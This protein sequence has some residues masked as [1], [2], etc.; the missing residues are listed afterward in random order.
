M[1]LAPYNYMV[2]PQLLGFLLI[3]FLLAGPL[4]SS[5]E[6]HSGFGIGGARPDNARGQGAAQS[7]L[8]LYTD[9]GAHARDTLGG[10][11]AG[12][13]SLPCIFLGHTQNLCLGRPGWGPGVCIS[14]VSVASG[15]GTTL[16][17][18]GSRANSEDWVPQ[19]PSEEGRGGRRQ[20]RGRS[21]EAH[22]KGLGAGADSEDVKVSPN[23]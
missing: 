15:P 23:T 1:F 7:S 11:Q 6:R 10:A 5:K 21:Q 8:T 17:A 13:L 14:W 16:W 12:E 19:L 18:P 4:S 9:Q 20:H 22:C 3:S 2:Q